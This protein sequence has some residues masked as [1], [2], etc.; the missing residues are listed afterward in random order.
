MAMTQSESQAL[1][2]LRWMAQVAPSAAAEAVKRTLRVWPVLHVGDKVRHYAHAREVCEKF[3]P[4]IR[5]KVAIANAEKALEA[6]ARLF[7]G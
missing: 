4:S 7:I 1:D 2:A 3:C 5:G 6:Q